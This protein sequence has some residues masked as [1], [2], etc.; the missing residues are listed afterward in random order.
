[1]MIVIRKCVY[2]LGFSP[3][4]ESIFYSP[5]LALRQALTEAVPDHQLPTD[6]EVWKRLAE[7]QEERKDHTP[8]SLYQDMNFCVVCGERLILRVLDIKECPN[9]HGKTFTTENSQG[10]PVI[11]F[12]PEEVFKK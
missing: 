3:Q 6:L 4:A 8:A 5:S 7:E 9:L 11:M 10:I 12:E 2:R 1:M